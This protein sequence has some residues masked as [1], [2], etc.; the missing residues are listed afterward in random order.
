MTAQIVSLH[1]ILKNKLGQILSVS[2]SR[3]VITLNHIPN[4]PLPGLAEGLRDIQKGE[5][6]EIF[7]PAAQAY[8]F[9]DPNKVVHRSR[10]EFEVELTVGSWVRLNSGSPSLKVIEVSDETVTFDGNH[11]L[12][13]QD[14]IFEVEALDA[15]PATAEEITENEVEMK[16]TTIH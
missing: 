7:V 2:F 16:T 4:S 9:Y 5:Q 13:G 6:R 14:L 1:C 11:P 3:D 10:E 8:G 12:A 15:R